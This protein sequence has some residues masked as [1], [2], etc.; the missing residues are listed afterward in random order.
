MMNSTALVL[1]RSESTAGITQASTA[2]RSLAAAGRAESTLR[3][4]RKVAARISD[5]HVAQG[6]PSTTDA[7]LAE[8]LAERHAKGIAPATLRTEIAAL[9]GMAKSVGASSPTG[10]QCR[11]VLAGIQREGKGRGR[12]QVTGLQYQDAHT[13]A[14]IES[15]RHRANQPNPAALRNAALMGLMAD[16]LLRVS[17]VAAVQAQ[18]IENGPRGT[19]RLLIHRS[20]TDQVGSGAVAFISRATMRHIR[21]YRKVAGVDASGPFF[22]RIGKGGRVMATGITARTA[23]NIIRQVAARWVDATG[24]PKAARYSGHSLRVGSAQSLV[25]AGATL[26][27]AMQAGRWTAPAMVAHYTRA[28]AASRNAVARLLADQ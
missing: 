6:H 15:R 13:A 8:Y 2:V 25:A 17:E 27:E 12:G 23:R 19:G 10:P 20:K 5:W 3:L 9:N 24:R 14:G 11:A 21:V 28:E 16:G 7:T 22:R 1:Q 18:D 4:Y 26:S